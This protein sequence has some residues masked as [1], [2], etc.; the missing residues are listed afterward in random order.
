MYKHD[1]RWQ[2]TVDLVS[3]PSECSQTYITG[4]SM[5]SNV[6]LLFRL[7]HEFGKLITF[8]SSPAFAPYSMP[9]FCAGDTFHNQG[10]VVKSVPPGFKMGHQNLYSLCTTTGRVDFKGCG[11]S[12][13]GDLSLCGVKDAH[14]IESYIDFLDAVWDSGMTNRLTEIANNNLQQALPLLDA[15]LVQSSAAYTALIPI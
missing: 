3:N 5:G 6:A 12:Y 11:A 2:E 14:A 4:H 8:A 1:P 7:E 10:D 9:R 13:I 15:P